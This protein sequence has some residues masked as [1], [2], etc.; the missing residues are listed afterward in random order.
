[1]IGRAL[2]REIERHFHVEA[3][4]GGNQAPEVRER[5]ERGMDGIVATFGAAYGVWAAR[6]ARLRLERVV[7]P[8]RLVRPIGWIG[9]R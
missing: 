6:I 4:A 7:A 8:L 1:M 2:D 9:V 5:S 3:V